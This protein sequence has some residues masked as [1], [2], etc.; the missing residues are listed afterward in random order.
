MNYQVISA[1]QSDAI[2]VPSDTIEIYVANHPFRQLRH[3]EFFSQALARNAHFL[4][5]VDGLTVSD[6]TASMLE[7]ISNSEHAFF[8]LHY[9]LPFKNDSR[10]LLQDGDLAVMREESANYFAYY[11]GFIFSPESVPFIHPAEG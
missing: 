3:V 8:G 4:A 11:S 2:P 10:L 7:A 6:V 1:C 5:C 9:A